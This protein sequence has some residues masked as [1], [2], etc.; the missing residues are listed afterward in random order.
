MD[1][2]DKTINNAISVGF[3]NAVWLENLKI[4]CEPRL[5]EYCNPEGCPKHGNNWV[6]PPGSGS[7][8]ECAEKVKEFSQGILLQS[9]TD[10]NPSSVDYAVLNKKHNLRLQNF[11][12]EHCKSFAKVLALTS[13]G[14]VFCEVCAYPKPCVK[15]NL[16][17]NS[18]SAY[19]ID[20]GKLCE[21]GK[22]EYAFRSDKLYLIALVL[23]K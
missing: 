17:M 15:P 4:E 19:G 8:K 9:I 13:G 10:I 23:I 3:T 1:K 16:R 22:M 20:V 18:L 5:R 14:C 11:L 2:N 6:C 21:A 12:E 7:L